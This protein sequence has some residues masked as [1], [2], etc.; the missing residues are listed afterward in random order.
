MA[1]AAT[2]VDSSQGT[3][4]EP[5]LSINKSTHGGRCWTKTYKRTYCHYISNVGAT[6]VQQPT[7]V[8]S[9]AKAIPTAAG[10]SKCNFY[11]EGAYAIPYHN[12]GVST[13]PGTWMRDFANVDKVRVLGFGFKI[14]GITV[15]QEQIVT[16]SSSTSLENT[17][18]GKPHLQMFIDHEHTYD[19]HVGYTTA[20]GAA[21]TT[22][23]HAHCMWAM[24]GQTYTTQTQSVKP[25]NIGPSQ[26]TFVD[27]S[28]ISTNNTWMD[29]YPQTQGA[30]ELPHVGLYIMESGVG[31]SANPSWPGMIPDPIFSY[32]NRHQFT[33]MLDCQ[34]IG[35]GDTPGYF[36][37]NPNPDWRLIGRNDYSYCNHDNSI[38]S[39][40]T[41]SFPPTRQ[42]ALSW[43][44]R[45][46]W[47]NEVTEKGRNNY[48]KDHDVEYE[49]ANRPTGAEHASEDIWSTLVPPNVFLKV[50]PL[51]GPTGAINIT[52]QVMI[53]YT[54][55]LEFHEGKF[56][57]INNFSQ[58]APTT[59]AIGMTRNQ[60]GSRAN[61]SVI[62]PQGYTI[63]GISSFWS[64]DMTGQANNTATLL[65][66]RPREPEVV[67][68]TVFK[69]ITA[70]NGRHEIA[71]RMEEPRSDRSD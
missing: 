64:G 4:K 3:I 22:A 15:L 65:G 63:G 23:E 7:Q 21:Q 26:P 51:L 55:E 32:V 16:R 38:T 2:P 56:G 62:D 18:Q 33:D 31:T 46:F 9:Y 70:R 61:H 53:E 8:N 34:I 45:R 11:Y 68:E 25:W 19:Q 12:V 24:I 41:T 37:K 47:F 35:E 5:N 52:A 42:A 39:N 49:Y 54:C 71:K 43:P 57:L 66:K 44:Y 6:P 58:I 59:T 30:G 27:T 13:V 28:I 10:Q 67:A 60:Y 36:W 1:Q 40:A 17:F 48:G 50:E 20:A 69:Q 29:V 14:K